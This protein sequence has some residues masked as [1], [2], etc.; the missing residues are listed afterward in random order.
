MRQI[1]QTALVREMVSELG[2]QHQVL[3]PKD[4][5]TLSSIELVG[6]Q[7]EFEH[8]VKLLAS[9]GDF[10]VTGAPGSGRYH[11]IRQAAQEVGAK[12]L[13]IDCVQAT[14]ENHFIDLFLSG[15]EKTFSSTFRQ[16]WTQICS[17]NPNI[18]K[19]F[20]IDQ[21]T[22]RHW[23]LA[24]KISKKDLWIA[25]QL[26]IDLISKISAKM[27]GRILIVL[28]RFSTI[29]SW[30]RK[31]TWEEFLRA[32][33]CQD[34]QI[35]YAIFGT[36]ADL[37]E[38]ELNTYEKAPLEIIQMRP[39]P[40]SVIAAWAREILRQSSLAFDPLDGSLD[41]FVDIVKGHIGDA[42]TLIRRIK[43]MYEGETVIHRTQI[44]SSLSQLLEDLAV[45]FESLLLLLPASQLQ[46][47]KCL[48]IEP[49]PKPHSKDYLKKYN[50]S[51]GGTLQGALTGLQQK[52]LIYG[53][54]D[55][56]KLTLSLFAAWIQQ[57][58]NQQH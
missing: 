56:F 44:Q 18:Q 16:T 10:L 42:E 52:G 31:H 32:S 23:E 7:Q 46:L 9:D 24:A 12:I 17:S 28:Q 58:V 29:R 41:Y 34:P 22:G 27:E 37:Q 19:L 53:S 38:E 57:T 26:V 30:D 25:F 51:R 11:F 8:M 54:E 45:V 15:I 49:T 13:E 43:L 14:N 21:R 48:A 40:N 55:N 50:L 39:L 5:S 3:H 20:N 6:R 47:I 4:R 36:I 35:S 1:C 2:T 33:I